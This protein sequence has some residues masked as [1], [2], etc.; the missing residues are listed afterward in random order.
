MK[1]AERGNIMS[2]II[3]ILIAIDTETIIKAYGPNQDLNN[4]R[5]I[6]SNLIRM[7]VRQGNVLS[8]Q[9]SGE[10]NVQA[11]VDDII[12]WRETSLSLS[13]DS[14]AVLY[15]YMP[16]FG[17][18]LISEVVAHKIDLMIP[19]PNPKDPLNPKIQKRTSHFWSSVVKGQGSVIYT[20]RFFIMDRNKKIVG[21]YSWDPYITIKA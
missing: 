15:K 3:N 8:E 5:S 13:D 11:Q 20:F 4:P 2:E 12:Q 21:Y 10:L 19:L 6:C 9:A 18:E 1:K 16:I 14:N 17:G 7:I